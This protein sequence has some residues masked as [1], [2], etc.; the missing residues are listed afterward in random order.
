LAELFR[1]CEFDRLGDSA[2]KRL[3]VPLQTVG[4]LWSNGYR[5]AST[6]Q[7]RAHLRQLKL[8]AIKYVGGTKQLWKSADELKVRCGEL[9]DACSEIVTVGSN[10]WNKN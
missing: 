1:Q 4:L 3:R 7:V 10:R 2:R 6:A 5:F 8:P 9:F